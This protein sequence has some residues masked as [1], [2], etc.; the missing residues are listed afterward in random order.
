MNIL[1]DDEGNWLDSHSNMLSIIENVVLTT[2]KQEGFSFDVEISLTL[3]D[4]DTIKKINFDYRNIDAITDVISFPQID[5]IS[6][7]IAPSEY[8]NPVEGD[9][10]LGDIIIS[11]QQ[12]QKQAASYEHSIEREC[13][14]LVAHSMLHLLGYDHLEMEEEDEMF[15]KQEAILQLIGLVR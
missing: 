1:V 5:W 13:A 15:A 12:L 7:N 3:T 9:I 14:F 6:E 11:T 2:L 4:D 8:I 10:L